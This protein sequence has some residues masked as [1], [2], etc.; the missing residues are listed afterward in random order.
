MKITRN[1]KKYDYDYKT[2]ILKGKYHRSIQ[3][4][5]NKENLPIGEMIIKLLEYYENSN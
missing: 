1:G 4:A 2:I 5:S 3:E